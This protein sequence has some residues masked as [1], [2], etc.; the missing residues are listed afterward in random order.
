METERLVVRPFT[1]ADC[2]AVHR[3]VGDERVVC[4]LPEG[5]WSLG[6]VREAIDWFVDCYRKNRPDRIIKFCVAVTLK[7]TGELIGWYG[8][9]PFDPFPEH[10]ELFCGFAPEH[11][12]Q[13]YGTEAGRALLGYGFRILGLPEIV[14]SVSPANPG[15]RR[16]VE[17]LG[18]TFEETLSG[19]PPEHSDYE[20]HAYFRYKR[21]D[22]GL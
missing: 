14:A 20:S 4:H 8:L 12:G 11:W 10:I 22:F 18:F 15:S 16:L 1:M 21:Q 17:K 13:G 2:H 9:G 3:L 6:Q 7:E 19:L 5:V